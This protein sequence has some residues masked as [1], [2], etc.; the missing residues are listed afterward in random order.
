MK[1]APLENV[2]MM[3]LVGESIILFSF[4]TFVK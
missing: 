1:S 4:I 3:G 2:V